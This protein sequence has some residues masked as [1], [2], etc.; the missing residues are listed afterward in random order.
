M[1]SRRRGLQLIG[2]EL[3]HSVQQQ[4]GG[5]LRRG[6]EDAAEREA[7]QVS[8][9]VLGGERASVGEA[10]SIGP[11][12][13]LQDYQNSLPGGYDE[14]INA[15][16]RQPAADRYRRDDRISRRPICRDRRN[17]SALRHT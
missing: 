8:G 10:R 17:R 13:R 6:V 2:H 11:A 5:A 4:R 9:R 14:H 16:E 12:F 15:L 3:V 7:E 1:R